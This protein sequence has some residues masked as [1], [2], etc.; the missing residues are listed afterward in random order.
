[1][2]KEFP[3]SQS[4]KKN[5]KNEYA[6]KLALLKESKLSKDQ[7]LWMLKNVFLSRFVD[8]AEIRMKKQNTAFFQISGAGH[9]GIL[10]AVSMILRPTYDYFISY[11]RDRA[12]CL[13]LGVSPYE[14]LCQ[15]NGNMG[16]TSSKGRQMPAHFGNVKLNIVNKSSCTGTQFLQAVGLAE[17]GK[18]LQNLDHKHNQPFHN[19]EIVYVSTGDGTTSQ[20]EF[21]EAL[22]TAVVN[23]LPVMFMVEDNGYAISVPVTDQTPE[24]SISKALGSFPGLKI[25]EVDGNCPIESY[26]TV[27]QAEKYLRSRKVPS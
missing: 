3:K 10:T 24:G 7:V 11:Y 5:S 8:D 16:D 17:G 19:D 20:G 25:L 6:Q 14:M 18:Y 26:S 27:T 22:T 4:T 2:K 9:E 13:G 23:K 1:M 15:A 21:W 12:L